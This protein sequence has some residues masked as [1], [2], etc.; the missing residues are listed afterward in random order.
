MKITAD[1][2]DVS[3]TGNCGCPSCIRSFAYLENTI[4]YYEISNAGADSLLT[5]PG[6]DGSAATPGSPI[7]IS[8]TIGASTVVGTV[9][10]EELCGAETS[11]PQ[12]IGF[13]AVTS[14]TLPKWWAGSRPLVDVSVFLRKLPTVNA[15]F[16]A[17]DIRIST[18]ELASSG[19]LVPSPE[20]PSLALVGSGMITLA[21]VLRR[22]VK[23]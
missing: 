12:V 7:W 10:V 2:V 8:I 1:S 19:E 3:L 16:Q 20:L 22:R 18:K 4:G 9:N 14:S 6:P 5:G 21:L 17:A 15:I 11:V 23:S 13:I